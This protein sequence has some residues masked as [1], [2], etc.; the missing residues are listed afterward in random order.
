MKSLRQEIPAAK[1]PMVVGAVDLLDLEDVGSNLDGLG[2]VTHIFYAAF[3]PGT[4]AAADY[5]LPGA[6][7]SHF[8]SAAPVGRDEPRCAATCGPKSPASSA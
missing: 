5:D 6:E 3:Q 1:K 4:G 2:D 7:S 8:A